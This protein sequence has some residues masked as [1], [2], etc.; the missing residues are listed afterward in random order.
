MVFSVLFEV[1]IR[2][3][4]FHNIAESNRALLIG[5]FILFA[6]QVAASG[7]YTRSTEYW[8][9]KLALFI[10]FNMSNFLI[11]FLIFTKKD[12]RNFIIGSIVVF[13]TGN[14]AL[15]L[16]LHKYGMAYFFMGEEGLGLTYLSWGTFYGANGLLFSGLL[17]EGLDANRK[18]RLLKRVLLLSI[19]FVSFGFCVISGAR[20]PAVFFGICFGGL[21]YKARQ[22]K[23]ICIYLVLFGLF[24]IA[25]V[26]KDVLVGADRSY[27]GNI[28]R[29]A[30][31]T[32]PASR[33][34]G[35][36]L[37]MMSQSIEFIS[38]KPFLGYGI[39]SFSI[40]TRHTDGRGYPHNIF[41]EVWLENGL[42]AALS[43][44]IFLCVS[45]YYCFSKLD[46]PF[47]YVKPLFWINLFFLMNCLKSYAIT[48]ARSFFLY[49]GIMLSMV[50]IE[51][52]EYP[53]AKNGGPA[54][55]AR[56]ALTLSLHEKYEDRN[57]KLSEPHG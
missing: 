37:S 41:L 43:L 17:L 42:I 39:G 32:D 21:L 7:L 3:R 57:K 44:F 26:S 2:R 31:L 47:P 8:K 33:S 35:D 45:L 29:F 25:V 18:S 9:W 46:R 38:E 53:F 23:T 14:I 51:R 49:L 22:W 36:R 54:L 28:R 6:I 11:P 4:R 50:L 56:A 16:S 27:F 12:V 34:V 13:I 5:L 20:G 10:A 48:D 19:S 40:I 24:I 15:L 55:L 30:L 52:K 1:V